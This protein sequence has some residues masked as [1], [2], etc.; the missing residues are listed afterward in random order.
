MRI[1]LTFVILF[2]LVHCSK[3]KESSS[4]STDVSPKPSSESSSSKK[5][6]GPNG[7]RLYVKH[8]QMC[9][10][11][12]GRQVLTGQYDLAISTLDLEAIQDVTRTG[13]NT[14]MS[15]EIILSEDEITAVSEFTLSLQDGD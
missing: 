11:K 3:N 1:I 9:H 7:K 10:G 15:Y 5:S 4:V 6:D 2:L 14:M 12:N 13:R 8:C